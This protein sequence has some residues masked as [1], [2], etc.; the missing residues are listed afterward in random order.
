MQVA[1][2]HPGTQHSRQTALA[3]QQLG[4]LAFLAT[5]LFDHPE[6]PLRHASRRLPRS[7]AARIERELARYAFPALDPKLVRTHG[8]AEWLE[9]LTRRTGLEGLAAHIDSFGNDRFG[10]RIARAAARDGPHALWGYSSS[11]LRAFAHPASAGVPRILDRSI[12]DWRCWNRELEAIRTGHPDWL[13]PRQRPVSA[14]R[15]AHDDE[16]F[17]L[18][19]RIL[20]GS[21]FVAESIRKHSP[22]P[23]LVGKLRV[24]PYCWDEALFG[25]APEPELRP[26]GEPVRFLFVG[27]VSARKGI[28]HLLEAIVRLPRGAATLTLAGPLA[29]PERTLARYADRID[30]RGPLHRSE[31][32]ALMQAHDALVF[33]SH[34][35]G[36]AVTLLEAMASG[37]ALIQTTQAGLGMSAE[38]GFAVTPDADAVEAAMR[39]LHADRARLLAMR[40]AAHSEAAE[41]NFARYCAAIAALLD[42]MEI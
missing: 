17:A 1:V 20:C 15:I 7:A 11:S 8:I 18:A 14:E 31:I 2:F 4:R 28:Q 42:E 19:T 5:S 30:Y 23:A 12:A 38:S 3:L 36:S 32:P 25:G 40:R 37:L 33:P 29:V 21:P 22:V 34:F 39:A 35:E 41:F 24:L 13:M 10:A 6:H 16:E 27:Q 9:R 26:A